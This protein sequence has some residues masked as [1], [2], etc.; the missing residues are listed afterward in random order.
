MKPLTIPQPYKATGTA[1]HSVDEWI[2]KTPLQQAQAH[3]HIMRNVAKQWA[4]VH[5]RKSMGVPATVPA[6]AQTLLKLCDEAL[7]AIEK[8]R[9]SALLLAM[10]ATAQA[11]ELNRWVAI[12]KALEFHRSAFS[13]RSSGGKASAERRFAER[14]NDVIKAWNE[15]E[16]IKT[17]ARDRIGIITKKLRI[18]RPTVAEHLDRAGLKPKKRRKPK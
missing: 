10:Q 8:E 12:D 5:W 13:K 15:H 7:Q 16:K 14:H 3:L 18:S 17:P 9:E 2:E 6:D 4:G 1:G 11:A